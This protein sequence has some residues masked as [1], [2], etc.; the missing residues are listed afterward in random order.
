MTVVPSPNPVVTPHT[1][2]TLGLIGVGLGVAAGLVQLVAGSNIPEWSGNKT[3]NAALGLTTVILSLVA[4]AGL[5]HLRHNPVRWQRIGALLLVIACA[6]VCFTTV[7]RLWYL[8]GPVIIAAAVL[9]FATTPSPVTAGPRAS[10][11]PTARASVGAGGWLLYAVAVAVGLGLAV[12]TLFTV[13][14]GTYASSVAVAAAVA[15]V[16]GLTLS[17][18]VAP[19]L[20]RSALAMLAG[21][22]GAGLMAGGL[23]LGTS[24]LLIAMG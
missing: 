24:A 18:G 10:T 9:T 8:P 1:A 21:G 6:G 22:L 7:G 5:W 16:A 13:L 15:V 17:V 20:R 4:A 11:G 23:V 2:R 19:A 3:D 14:L 12:G